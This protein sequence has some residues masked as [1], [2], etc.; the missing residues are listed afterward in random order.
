MMLE[1][2]ISITFKVI[3]SLVPASYHRRWSTI[4]L[5]FRNNKIV[6]R[7]STDALQ[8]PLLR[9]G[10][11]VATCVIE[12]TMHNVDEAVPIATGAFTTASVYH[13]VLSVWVRD[14]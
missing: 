8:I 2:V 10:A 6:W 14:P 7:L 13:A 3:R 1:R 5:H 12:D 9:M 4:K 11:L